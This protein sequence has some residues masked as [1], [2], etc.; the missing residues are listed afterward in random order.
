[1]TET[2]IP[3]ATICP[4]GLY[5]Y[6]LGRRWG[7]G[8]MVAFLMLNPS[9]AD[10]TQDDPTIR[11]CVGFARS[12]GAGA[13]RVVNLWAY[14]ATKPADLW[15][16]REL[17]DVVGPENDRHIRRAADEA[18]RVVAAWGAHGHRDPKRVA[19]VLDL[20]GD[21]PLYCLGRTKGGDPRHPLMVRADQ[22]LEPF[23]AGVRP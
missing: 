1:M 18:E 15:G 12:W 10:A 6:D 16:A 11:R 19:A 14:R 9:T 7:D 22:P 23:A 4:S 5:R 20:L 3:T 17:L 21:R 13:I 2:M 8:A